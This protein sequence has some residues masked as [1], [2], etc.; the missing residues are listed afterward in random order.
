MNVYQADFHWPAGT[1]IKELRI[2]QALAKSTAPP[3]EP[4]I[5]AA[6]QTNARAVLGTVPVEADGSAYFEAPPGKAIYFQALDAD[7][8]AVQSMRSVT[9]VHPGEQLVCNGCHEPKH[10]RSTAGNGVPLAL[11]RAPAPI[12]GDVDGARPFSYVR[13]VQPV[14]DRNC[15]GC[16][17]EKKALDLCG[18]IE[19]KFGWSRSYTNL[20]AK[21][22]FFFTVFNGSIKDPVHGGSR[23]T[24]GAFGAQASKLL[25]YLDSRHYGVR[26]SPEDRHRLTLWLDC[27]SEFY[28]AVRAARRPKAG[29]RSFG[30]RWSRPGS[31]KGGLEV[32]VPGRLDRRLSGNVGAPQ[33]AIAGG[34]SR[35]RSAFRL[36]DTNGMDQP[37][38]YQYVKLGA[39]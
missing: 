20:A 34:A 5:G 27:N 22:G 17:A 24:A 32:A 18:A 10:R 14:L 8:L 1:K 39:I 2:V 11:L 33:W 4:R 23:T 15:A 36:G 6:E 26:L 16:H 12:R 35:P 25:N 29:A 30:P 21:Y 7:G 37:T 28:G 9:Y 38:A 13:L 19:G 31:G 3:N